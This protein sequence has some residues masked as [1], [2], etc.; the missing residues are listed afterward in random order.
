MNDHFSRKNYNSKLTYMMRSAIF[1][2]DG[3]D[4]C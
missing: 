4:T 3:F 1:E 2:N